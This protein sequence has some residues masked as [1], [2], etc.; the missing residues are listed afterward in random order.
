MNDTSSSLRGLR[1]KFVVETRVALYHKELDF[2]FHLPL[3]FLTE[4]TTKLWNTRQNVAADCLDRVENFIRLVAHHASHHAYNSRLFRYIRCNSSVDDPV[5][6]DGYWQSCAAEGYGRSS[7][8]ACS[9]KTG[10]E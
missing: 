3:N 8:A 6:I 4:V 7:R 2:D 1:L 5:S 9:K 10:I